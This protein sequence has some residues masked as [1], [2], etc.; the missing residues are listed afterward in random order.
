MPDSARWNDP[1][2]PDMLSGPDL[3]L[4]EEEMDSLW[5]LFSAIAS[6][7]KD[8]FAIHLLRSRWRDMVEAYSDGDPSYLAEYRNAA[9]T[10]SSLI[11]EFGAE[12][13][14]RKF[15][16][17]TVITKS[18]EALTRLLHAKFYVGNQFIGCFL[19]AGG[20]RAFIPKAR[21]YQGFMGGSRFREWPPVRTGKRQ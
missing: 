21:N 3:A 9:G 6:Y 8:D 13:A 17:E 11:S 4:S 16:G 2:P 18:D 15:Y 14:M 10:Y 1:L 7:W 5:S 19:A 20:F 12:G